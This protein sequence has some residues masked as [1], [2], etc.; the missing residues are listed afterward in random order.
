MVIIGGLSMIDGPRPGYRRQ[1]HWQWTFK[2]LPAY[3]KS[4][5]ENTSVPKCCDLTLS[6]NY[7]LLLGE[8][9]DIHR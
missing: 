7:Y 4:D 1:K 8:S 2:S 3:G 5:I 6:C 9:K